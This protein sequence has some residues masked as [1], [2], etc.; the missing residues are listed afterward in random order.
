[1]LFSPLPKK[2]MRPHLFREDFLS[3]FLPGVAGLLWDEGEES[4]L[5]LFW[6]T[7]NFCLALSNRLFTDLNRRVLIASVTF[8]SWFVISSS[9]SGKGKLNL[10]E[11]SSHL[12]TTISSQV[13]IRSVLQSEP[14]LTDSLVFSFRW[15]GGEG[16]WKISSLSWM[17]LTS[18][19]TS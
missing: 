2:S 4:R 12:C 5:P 16:I 18:K 17:S 7:S 13:L 8:V 15:T 14:P 1:M 19:A 6:R 3:D 9:W 11:S 10:V